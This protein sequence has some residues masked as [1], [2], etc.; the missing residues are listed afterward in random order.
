MK[1]AIAFFLVALLAPAL[2]PARGSDN[3]S[4]AIAYYL[5]GDL[6]LARK[7]LDATTAR[8]RPSSASAWPRPT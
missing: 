2:F 4:R 7:S 8:W 5:V 3:F 6:D 1:K